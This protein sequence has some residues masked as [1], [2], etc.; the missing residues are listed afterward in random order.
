[1]VLFRE[2][3]TGALVLALLAFAVLMASPLAVAQGEPP[4]S[5]TAAKKKRGWQTLDA[6]GG[7]RI[8]APPGYRLRLDKGA[9]EVAG[10]AGK[11][12]LLAV[13]TA[14]ATRT[15]AE[16]LLGR[17]LPATPNPDQ[18]GMRLPL[19]RGGLA[20]IYFS[21][22]SPGF[23]AVT[24]LSPPKKKGAKG[25]R[26]GRSRLASASA[27]QLGGAQ[28]R[29][30][31]RMARSA[32]GLRAVALP[33]SASQELE[34]PIPLKAFTTADGSAKA[35]VPDAPGWV[36]GGS[37]GIVEGYHPDLGSYAFGV[38]GGFFEAC[39]FPPCP[40]IQA[41]F[42]PVQPALEQ[43]WPLWLNQA[44]ANV[45]NLRVVSQVPNSTGVLGPGY[46]SGMFQVSFLSNGKPG[47]AYVIAGV[48]TFGEGIWYLY[49]S[50]IAAYDGVSGNVGDALLRT[51]QSWDPSVNQAE[52]R[53][54]TFVTL[55]ETTQIIQSASEYRR[56]VFEKTNYNW[57]AYIRG[58]DPVLDPVAPGVIG[59]GN[60]TLV[61]GPDGK[62]F[63]FAGS[64][65]KK[66]GE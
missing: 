39:F 53:A 20:E 61:Q 31:A 55:Q 9:Y 60:Q 49:Y 46:D 7:F 30:F 13:S 4:G 19:K 1:M 17:A 15:V 62:L 16:A 36:A 44:G 32:R 64:Q 26:D 33:T 6:R 22:P 66:P 48:F 41:P 25:K 29:L 42:M 51:W 8:Q 45:S 5:A 54:Q 24:A 23:V 28:R 63:N 47:T 38:L 56:K 52:R 27:A 40:G 57:S 3:I 14:G 2:R 35:M 21:R 18:F 34:A 50:Y 59:E 10:R 58:N 12:T 11:M 43:A 65:F 37:K